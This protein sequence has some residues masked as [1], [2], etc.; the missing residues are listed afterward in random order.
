ML[1]INDETLDSA[2]L[3]ILEEIEIYADKT[4]KECIY[5]KLKDFYDPHLFNFAFMDIV[6]TAINISQGL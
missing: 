2:D 5:D 6:K 3:N 4:L 1:L